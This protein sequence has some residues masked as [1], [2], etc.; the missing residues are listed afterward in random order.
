MKSI[1]S[2]NILGQ[3]V[4]MRVDF[5]IPVKNGKI[6]DDF[7]IQRI[8]P[9][10]QFLRE[11]KAKKI[12]LI[13][14][15]GQP[16]VKDKNKPAFSLAPIASYLER[17]IGETIY[18]TATLIGK[19]V[20]EEIE[21]L[22]DGSVILLENIRF[23]KE[24][25]QNDKNFAKELAK[26]ADIFINEAFSVCHRK[27]SSL[28][29]ITEF[30]PSYAGILLEEELTNLNK[31]IQKPQHPLVVILGGAKIKNKISVIEKF[32]DKA[33]FILLGGI[34]A[35]T[36]LKANDFSI[37]KSFYDEEAFILAEKM[38]TGKAEL[39]LPGD[40]IVLDKN[41]Q[42]Q[43]RE[44]GKIAKNDKILD[45]GL[46]ACDTFS[47]VIFKAKTVFFNGPM[48]KFEDERFGDGTNKII[49]AIIKNKSAFSVIGGG[50]TLFAFKILKPEYRI[51]NT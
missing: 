18:F 19:G 48:G 35:N 26:M 4:L 31:V 41:N 34:M 47:K 45:I 30:L 9:T 17:L 3:L 36:F 40:F 39:L 37:G 5:N 22:P 10:I 20:K 14:H 15:L 49:N 44:L 12:I 43:T 28:C 33:D 6:L 21:N 25:N 50:D 46:I 32:K 23:Y 13:S 42:K 51:Q 1:R 2:V 11:K 8:L 29:A 27:T 38:R 24:E 7:R 16:D